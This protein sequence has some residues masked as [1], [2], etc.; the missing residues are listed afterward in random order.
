[1]RIHLQTVGG[2]GDGR[3]SAAVPADGENVGRKHAVAVVL[4]DHVGDPLSVRRPP[5]PLAAS[6]RDRI[7]TG[8]VGDVQPG[9]DGFE[10]DPAS[11][12]GQLGPQNPLVHRSEDIGLFPWRALHGDGVVLNGDDNL[13]SWA[14]DLDRPGGLGRLRPSILRIQKLASA[15][16]PPGQ[17]D[18]LDVLGQLRGRALVQVVHGN[19]AEL[20]LVLQPGDAAGD[21]RPARIPGG[22]KTGPRQAADLLRLAALP[23]DGPQSLV[24]LTGQGQPVALRGPQRLHEISLS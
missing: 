19:G 16:D 11:V 3:L 22:Q 10:G 4:G 24:V 1:M 18:L 13:L 15:V 2:L 8:Q 17:S 12:G 14:I 23:G 9:A 5:G 6:Q 20:A 7:G 21:A